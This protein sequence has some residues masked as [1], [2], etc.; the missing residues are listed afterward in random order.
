MILAIETSCDETCA[1]VCTVDGRLL[2]SVV[3]S[4]I[5]DHAAFGGVVPE[6]ASRRHL[7]LLGPAVAT[8]L[9]E[10]GVRDDQ[11]TRVAVT[12]GPGLIGALLV[13][14]SYA[15]GYAFAR[16]LPLV[17]VDHL[18]GH[19]ASLQLAD[20]PPVGAH[21][22]L[23]ASGGH[24]LLIDVDDEGRLTTIARSLDDAAGEAFDKG[25]RLLGLGYPGGP[26]LAALAGRADPTARAFTTPLQGREDLA[27]SFSG[28]KT[29]LA[30][31]V[32]RLA[33][34]DSTARSELAAAYQEAIVDHLLERAALGLV[35]TDRTTL[36]L[37]GGVAA[38]ARLRE[39]L[40]EVQATV[41]MAPLTVCGDNAAMIAIA[42]RSLLPLSPPR[43][44]ALDA[45][46]RSPLG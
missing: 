37:V 11:L 15:K 1:A 43:M 41:A 22:V 32:Q 30:L 10:A 39:R 4:Q 13:G 3:A 31:A 28:L 23:L 7:E 6:I 24:T 33:D 8:A 26:A 17:A 20:E 46:A 27:F 14:V 44:A 29:A 38:N 16:G 45:H 25:A 19:V 35:S 42:S 21:L 9:A 36:G 12:V 2:S 40:G 34:G 5:A 18:Q